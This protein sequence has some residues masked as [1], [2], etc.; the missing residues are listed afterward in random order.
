MD[1]WNKRNITIKY[2]I[3]EDESNDIPKFTGNGK[4][5]IRE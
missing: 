5:E 3:G 2:Q 4:G 1:W